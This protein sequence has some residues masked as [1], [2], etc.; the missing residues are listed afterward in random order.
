MAKVIPK[1]KIT[2]VKL[3]D[4]VQFFGVNGTQIS[5]TMDGLHLRWDPALCQAGVVVVTSDHYP[6]QEK[7]LMGGSIATLSWAAEEP[8]EDAIDHG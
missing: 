6:G 5:A 8:A 4:G 3:Y 7:W 1:M 2:F